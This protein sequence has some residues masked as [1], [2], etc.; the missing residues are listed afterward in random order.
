[1]T[2]TPR[3]V[4]SPDDSDDW[5]LTVDLAAMAVSIDTALLAGSGLES[6]LP[7]TATNGSTYYATDTNMQF[8]RKGGA[9]K[10]SPN[11]FVGARLVKNIAQSTTTS[12]S[13]ISWN[14]VGAEFDT[15]NMYS[16]ATTTRLNIP[17]PGVWEVGFVLRTA[18][19]G[20]FTARIG[21]NGSGRTD[22]EWGSGGAAGGASTVGATEILNLSTPGYVYVQAEAN[23]AGTTYNAPACRFWATYL[24]EI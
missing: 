7:A 6:A 19:T 9:W 3:G 2:T 12:T 14:S 11:R 20:G 23:A 8:V 22:T 10:R 15:D 24:G 4:F 18:G 21:V 17:F 16:L 5:D 1:M 13:S